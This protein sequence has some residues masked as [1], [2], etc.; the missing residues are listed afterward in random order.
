MR[1][2][3]N[4]LKKIARELGWLINLII[5]LVFE[6]HFSPHSSIFGFRRLV[7]SVEE[8]NRYMLIVVFCT[9]C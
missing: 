2:K 8:R 5:D 4:Q 9:L 3:N 1:R 6:Q 7:L